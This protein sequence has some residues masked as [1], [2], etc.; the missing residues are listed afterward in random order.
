MATRL[1]SQLEE[2]GLEAISRWC[3]NRGESGV[4]RKS[5][6][7]GA[8]S[9]SKVGVKRLYKRGWE[10]GVIW[11]AGGCRRSGPWGTQGAKG[12]ASAKRHKSRSPPKR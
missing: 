10:T 8:F 4:L 12:D 1:D 11:V 5:G 9:G 7:F 3:V 2:N 6:G